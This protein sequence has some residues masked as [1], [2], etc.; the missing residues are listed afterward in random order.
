MS[1]TTDTRHE[2]VSVLEADTDL[3]AVIP[4]GEVELARRHLVVESITAPAGPWEPEVAGSDAIGLL[5]V[6]GLLL[7][8]LEIGPA[9]SLELLGVGDLLRPWDI[10]PDPDLSPLSAEVAWTIFEPARFALLD[11]RFA[12]LL[13]RWPG[14]MNELMRRMMRRSRWLAVRLAISSLQSVADRVALLLWHLASSWGRVTPD[15]TIVPVSLTHE[16]IAEL[17]GARRPS[18]TTAIG[19]LRDAGR[20]ERLPEG[21]LLTAPPPGADS[22]R[23]T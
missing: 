7:R 14:L 11:L 13:G 6:E 17:I 4:S 1:S 20:V 23:G 8:E 10:E 3:R 18:V 22:D 2:L 5:V 19:E 21:W 9:R 15:G 16:L 12:G